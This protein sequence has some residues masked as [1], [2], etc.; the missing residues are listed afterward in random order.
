VHKSEAVSEM[1]ETELDY[2]YYSSASDQIITSE[3][4][5]CPHCGA[6]TS[7]LVESSQE[8]TPERHFEAESN[9]P[10]QWT[11]GQKVLVVSAVLLFIMVI[12]GAFNTGL[13]QDGVIISVG[14]VVVAAGAFY[15]STALLWKVLRQY[16]ERCP[17]CGANGKYSGWRKQR[18][19][20]VECSSCGHCWKLKPLKQ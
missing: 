3:A 9:Q 4:R 18:S 11:T 16:N 5:T 2:E 6:D 15:S 19:M 14:K 1:K 20:A 12:F 13:P 8:V 7:E 17:K 10:S